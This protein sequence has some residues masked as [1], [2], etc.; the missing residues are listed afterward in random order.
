MRS[1]FHLSIQVLFSIWMKKKNPYNRYTK[2]VN[3]TDEELVLTFFHVSSTSTFFYRKN[4]MTILYGA[5][6]LI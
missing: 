1:G 2:K 4:N 6:P 5:M 3:S